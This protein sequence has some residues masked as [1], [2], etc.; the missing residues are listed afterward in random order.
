[1]APDT[2]SLNEGTMEVKAED[3]TS[4]VIKP[5]VTTQEGELENLDEAGLFLQKHNFTT[6]DLSALMSDAEKNRKIIRKIDWILMPLL[7]GTYFL[8]YIDKQALSYAAVFDLLKSTKTSSDQ[9]GWLVSIFYFAYLVFEWPSSYMVQHFPASRVLGSYVICWGVVLLCTA[10]SHNFT[11][12]AICRFLL[13]I[14][15]SV[16]TPCF[17]LVVGMWYVKQEQP[18]RAGLFYCFN[19]WGS[20]A[21]GILFYAVGHAKGFLIWRIIFLLCGGVTVVWGFVLLY[22]LPNDIMSAK[23]FTVDEK[24]LL[25]ARSRQNQTGVLNRKIKWDQVVE[26][27]TDPQVWLLFLF[28]LLNEVVN[29]GLANFG[30]LIIKGVAKNNALLTTV[31]GIPQSAF[32]VAF[33]FSGPYLAGKIK[34]SRTIIMAAYLIPSIIGTAML[35][36]MPR[37]NTIGC[38]FGYYIVSGCKLG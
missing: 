28:V 7:C 21:G 3:T 2:K 33:V 35:W 38:L 27:L 6:A 15:E 25:I 22:F 16:V 11:G 18:I 1:M 37:K 31:Y 14:F 20:M 4:T 8:Q 19:G 30:K 24:A 12:L 32:Q 5:V 9:Y 23:R 26:A 36:K 13:G 10:A 29:G 17:M 34:N